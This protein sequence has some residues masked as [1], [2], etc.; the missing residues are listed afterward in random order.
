[1]NVPAD[2]HKETKDKE[3]IDIMALDDVQK[4]VKDSIQTEKDAMDFYKYGA[5]RM[6][7]EKAQKTF[8]LL[9]REEYQHA[10]SFYR[11][12]TGDDIPSFDDFMKE[13]PNTESNWWQS[14]QKLLMQDF[15]ERKALELAIEQ[16]DAL[17]KSLREMASMI[18]DPEIAKVYLANATSTHNHLE[19]VEE[20]YK[21][22]FGMGG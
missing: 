10:E 19:L 3:E 6:M 12:Y 7:E 15:D 2:Y 11:I 5:E 16:E 4:A 14:L 1:M 21:A 8:E 9:A 22:M 13:P 20:D 17:E 18:D